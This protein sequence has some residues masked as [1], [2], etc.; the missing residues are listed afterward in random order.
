MCSTAEYF[1]IEV[2]YGAGPTWDQGGVLSELLHTLSRPW[3]GALR[4]EICVEVLCVQ[5]GD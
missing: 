2:S 5:V 3:S 1:D 4:G